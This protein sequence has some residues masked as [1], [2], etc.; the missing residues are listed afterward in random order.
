VNLVLNCDKS[1]EEKEKLLIEFLERDLKVHQTES[2]SLKRDLQAESLKKDL[3]AESLKKDLQT[4]AESLKINL[5]TQAESLKK[6]AQLLEKDLR[7]KDEK[8]GSSRRN[9]K[10]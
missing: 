6:E 10:R 2:E 9:M 7:L 3:Q 4:Q 1:L 5:Q 8:K